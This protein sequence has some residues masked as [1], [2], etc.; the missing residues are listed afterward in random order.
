MSIV[1]SSIRSYGNT[2][3][4]V[5]AVL[6]SMFFLGTISAEKG[7]RDDSDEII[8]APSSLVGK[9]KITKELRYSEDALAMLTPIH[10]EWRFVSREMLRS[11]DEL[12]MELPTD[13]ANRRNKDDAVYAIFRVVNLKHK[14][15]NVRKLTIGLRSQT[16]KTHLVIDV[17]CSPSQSVVYSITPVLGS[18]RYTAEQI[19][20][21]RSGKWDAWI[22]TISF[23]KQGKD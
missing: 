2:L 18:G 5:M 7:K 11:L 13:A 15:T 16:D 23:G 12:F 17:V 21:Y 10:I 6:V 19:D 4:V 8:F 20:L 3:V 1:G 9:D 14:T 22:E